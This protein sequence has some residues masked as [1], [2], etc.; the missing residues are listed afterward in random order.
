MKIDKSETERRILD[1]LK[2]E[3]GWSLVRINWK[4]GCKIHLR[5]GFGRLKVIQLR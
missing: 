3:P 2:D 5:N 4:K 1:A